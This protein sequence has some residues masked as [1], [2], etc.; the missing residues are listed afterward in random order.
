MKLEVITEGLKNLLLEN[1]YNS[2][3][4]HFYE[5]EWKKISTF[6]EQEYNDT[7]FDMEV[8]AQPSVQSYKNRHHDGDGCYFLMKQFSGISGDHGMSLST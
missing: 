8:N 3:T 5:R 7:E 1:N 6:L 2:T 4:I